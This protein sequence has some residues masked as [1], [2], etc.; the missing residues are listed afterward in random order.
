MANSIVSRYLDETYFTLYQRLRN[1]LTDRLADADLEVRL[2]GET[3]TIGAL[4]REI[5]EIEHTYVESSRTFRQDFS[6]R[7]PDLALERSVDAVKAWYAE[8]DRDFMAAV[9]A[10]STSYPAPRRL[11][12]SARRNCG[13]S[14]TTRMRALTGRA[15]SLPESRRR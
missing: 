12:T 9:A 13:S 7:N 3:E 2:G 5:G 11:V 8:L 15:R 4:C 1:E 10:L 14:S 6:Y